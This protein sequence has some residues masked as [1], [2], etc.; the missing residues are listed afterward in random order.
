MI[1]ANTDYNPLIYET[2]DFHAKTQEL[3]DWWWGMGSYGREMLSK[4]IYGHTNWN[5]L[6]GAE[7]K[8][9]YNKSTQ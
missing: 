3:M 5:T 6:T 1:S 9:L 4:S 2:S 8:A 7:I